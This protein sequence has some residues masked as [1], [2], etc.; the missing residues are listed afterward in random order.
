M[1]GQL[2]LGENIA[3]L[4][5]LVIGWDA[6]QAHLK[7]TGRKDIDG[8]SPEERFF[9]AFAQMERTIARP[10]V[11]KVRAL[12]DPH[13]DAPFRINGPL[14]NFDPF[15]EVFNIKQG[16]KLYREPSQRARIW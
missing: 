14:S 1:S 7:K 2:T 5:G 10:E 15:Y 9:L 4:G 6:Y 3:D 13:A 11:R 12:T 16:D 8:F